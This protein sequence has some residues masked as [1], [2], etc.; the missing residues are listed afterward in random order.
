MCLKINKSRRDFRLVEI[1]LS[2]KN[3]SRRF[4]TKTR[5]GRIPTE[6]RCG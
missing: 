2:T 3:A 1:E 5:L 4:A 6:C